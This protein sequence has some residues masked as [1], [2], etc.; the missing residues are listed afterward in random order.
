MVQ[1]R[2]GIRL[3]SDTCLS[4][5]SNNHAFDKNLLFHNAWQNWKFIFKYENKIKTI[6]KLFKLQNTIKFWRNYVLLKSQKRHLKFEE[7]E[8]LNKNYQIIKSIHEFEII[9][10]FFLKFRMIVRRDRKLRFIAWKF[11]FQSHFNF[12]YY[13]SFHKIF[14]K[15]TLAN[16]LHQKQ[17]KLLIETWQN[18]KR[19]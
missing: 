6:I 7:N 5:V 12:W 11:R 9:K 17:V 14:L 8:K 15:Q 3:G 2:N 13:Y 10:D 19:K 4:N 1:K 18:W 16:R